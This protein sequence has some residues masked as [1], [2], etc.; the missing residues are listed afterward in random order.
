MYRENAAEKPAPASSGELLFTPKAAQADAEKA[1][2]GAT[3]IVLAPLIVGVV[4]GALVSPT[5]AVVVFGG[6]V[7]SLSVVRKLLNDP[8]ALRVGERRLVVERVRR[9][10]VL[11]EASL[12]ELV[13]VRLETKEVR[14][15]QEGAH[16]VTGVRYDDS[17]TVTSTEHARLLL[18]TRT[19]DGRKETPLMKEFVAHMEA[20]EWLSKVRV[21]LRKH[22]WVPGDEREDHAPESE[23]PESEIP[24]SA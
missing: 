3:S 24:E 17:R 10:K 2:M 13:D 7:V 9:K 6:G 12:E 23:I 16:A 21:F 20:T 11:F 15:L 22:G 14:R 4:I 8:V 18:V 1:W 19:A 5:A